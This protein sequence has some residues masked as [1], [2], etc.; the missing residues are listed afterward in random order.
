[1]DSKHISGQ[2]KETSFTLFL[3]GEK[4]YSVLRSLIE[5]G[6]AA[7]IKK[8]V[9][10]VDSAVF[11]DFYSEIRSLAQSC[12]IEWSDRRD[13]EEVSS[14]YALAI[15]WRW[16]IP[17]DKVKLIV[18]HD[19]L[20]PRYRGFAPLVNMLLHHEPRIGATAI[21][22]TNE[23]DKGDI[24]AQE[25][26]DVNYPV[27]IQDAI[28]MITPIYS[29]LALSIFSA[30]C[31]GDNLEGVPQRCSLATYSLWRDNE[32]Y[33]I[34][35]NLSSEEILQH[36]YALGN[37]YLGAS[38]VM[39]NLTPVRIFDAEIVED[40]VVENRDGGKVIFMENGIP[41]VVC[42]KGLIKLTDI[43]DENGKSILPLRRFRTRFS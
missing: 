18:I 43:R 19:S 22:A 1:M 38:S 26:I 15:S 23:Y 25:S 30:A 24:I 8:V 3:M 28:D 27:R 4:G 32:D 11:N 5:S 29:K 16:M 39:N 37:P 41:T 40:V 6:Y 21:W 10:A 13:I 20:L 33:R 35:W 9:G 42:G 12:N 14:S 7:H 17:G 34:D 2:Y 36:I 31:N